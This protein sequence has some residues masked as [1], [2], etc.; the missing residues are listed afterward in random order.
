MLVE[1]CGGRFDGL[2]LDVESSDDV[3]RVELPLANMD[4]KQYHE[5]MH[6]AVSLQPYVIYKIVDDYFK[7]SDARLYKKAVVKDA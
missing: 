6:G 3:V 2:Q 1:L 7:G 4:A 5:M